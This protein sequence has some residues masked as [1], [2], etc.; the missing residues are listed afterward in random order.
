M[1]IHLYFILNTLNFLLCKRDFCLYFI[2]RGLHEP[3][4]INEFFLMNLLIVIF[5][6][7]LLVF[8]CLY[9]ISKDFI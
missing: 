9:L 5:A 4:L 2:Y 1:V 6:N 8:I 3:S 7:I